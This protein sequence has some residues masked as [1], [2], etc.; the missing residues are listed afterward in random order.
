MKNMY[1]LV[2]KDILKKIIIKLLGVK[3]LNYLYF[4]KIAL[5]TKAGLKA[6]A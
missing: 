6:I 4:L 2:K 3:R 5:R 1:F